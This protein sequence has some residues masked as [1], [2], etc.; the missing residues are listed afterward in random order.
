MGWED[1]QNRLADAFTTDGIVGNRLLQVIEAEK[2]YCAFIE[3]TLKGHS[4]LSHC[5]QEFCT[6]TLGA[7]ASVWKAKEPTSTPPSYSGVFP[8][9]LANF[10][11]IRPVDILF[12]SRYPMDGFARLRYLKEEALYLGALLSGLTSYSKIKGWDGVVKPG[13]VPTPEEMDQVSRNRKKEE[14]RVLCLMIREKSGLAPEQLMQLHR[15]ET[16]FNLEVHGARLTQALEHGPALRGEDTL[17]L[18]PKRR[19]ASCAMFMNRFSEVAWMLH[20]TLPILQLS[21]RRFDAAWGRKWQL[22]DDNFLSMVQSLADLGKPFGNVFVAFVS[23]KFP[24]EPE[25]CFDTH[26]K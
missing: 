23:Q 20:R 21:T 15:W 26:V 10:R 2:T 18:A 13:K 7:A 24:F 6:D 3:R 5:F 1:L 12:H 8:W 9:H 16:F 11:S 14:K 17:S 25:V 19:Q 22:L 4:I